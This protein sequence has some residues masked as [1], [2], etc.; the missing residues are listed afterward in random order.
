MW[1]PNNVGQARNVNFRPTVFERPRKI[2][3]ILWTGGQRR[4]A[5]RYLTARTVVATSLSIR[6]RLVCSRRGKIARKIEED[7]SYR[8]LAAGNFPAHRTTCDF[9]L[10]HLDE[11]DRVR[12]LDEQLDL[13]S[14]PS[15]GRR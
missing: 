15:M 1:S 11:L 4:G 14:E 10:I 8:V 5:E 2:Q 9:R 7:I 6:T 3:R 12:P 13:V